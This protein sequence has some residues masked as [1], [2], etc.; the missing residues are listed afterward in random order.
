MIRIRLGILIK[1]QLTLAGAKD[2][3]RRTQRWLAE[4]I[5]MS[6]PSLSNKLS[7]VESFSEEDLQK[8]EKILN[9]KIPKELREKSM[10]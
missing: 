2:G 9:I 6:Y 5:E 7:G 4:Q 1:N 3:L 10:A 8:I